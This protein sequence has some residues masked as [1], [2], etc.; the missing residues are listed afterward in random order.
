MEEELPI[1]TVILSVLI[2]ASYLFTSGNL[3]YYEYLLGF[4]PS[5]PNIYSFI[6]YTFIHVDIFHLTGNLVFLIIAGSILEKYLGKMYFL[7]IYICSGCIAATF[8]VLSRMI[9]GISMDIPF[10][11]A[12]G[13]IFGLISVASILKPM[14]KIPTI[15]VLLS[16][17]PLLNLLTGISIPLDPKVLFFIIVIF[18]VPIIGIGMFIVPRSISIF[19]ATLIFIFSWM[20]F[21]LLQL[22]T[23]TSNIGHLGGLI[24]GML[25]VFAFRKQKKT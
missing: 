15:L 9:I 13:S 24:G 19:L 10:V 1:V 23:S 8:D 11:G 6:T 22:P 5:R 14:E 18:S 21:L 12:S 4:V 2:L 25:S 3:N 16:F 17:L 20:L 7:S